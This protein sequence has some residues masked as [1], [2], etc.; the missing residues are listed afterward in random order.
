MADDQGHPARH[1]GGLVHVGDRRGGVPVPESR[2]RRATRRSSASTCHEPSVTHDLEILRVSHEV[3][4]DQVRELSER[5]EGRDK[6][7]VDAA[8][9]AA[10]RGRAYRREH[11]SRDAR[12]LPRRGNPR[13][14]LRRA[15]RRVGGVPRA[16][17]VLNRDQGYGDNACESCLGRQMVRILVL[18][19]DGYLGWPTAMHFSAR[20]HDVAVV[21][22]YTRRQTVA[23]TGSDSL[24][25]VLNLHQR[26]AAW[27]ELS[28]R[29]ID[30]HLF[31]LCEYEPLDQLVKT[32][33]ARGDRALRRRYRPRRTR[34]RTDATPFSPSGTTSRTT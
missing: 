22:N 30:V 23:E 25:P 29:S 18:G 15:A 14:D 5:R 34:C 21:D 13:R 3:E 19:G 26:V 27:K 10:R 32:F 24:T 31:D 28:G 1:R 4:V 20:G 33:R 2:W 12:R 9:D 11:D 8:L 16:S 7:V 6:A 17:A